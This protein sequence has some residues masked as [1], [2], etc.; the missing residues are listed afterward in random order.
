MVISIPVKEVV[1]PE[2]SGLAGKGLMFESEDE[3]DPE[4]KKQIEAALD[5]MGP[6]G[7][8]MLLEPKDE[9]E[10]E[11]SNDNDEDD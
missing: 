8:L 2:G 10:S 4:V 7:D 1:K 9:S 3:D 5:K 6:L 11:S